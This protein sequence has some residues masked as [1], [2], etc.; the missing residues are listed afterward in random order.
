MKKIV[1]ITFLILSFS[2]VKA[3][4]LND[5]TKELK[6]TS[7]YQMY[8][9]MG[10]TK[11]TNDNN[12]IT[13]KYPSIK[14]DKVINTV[15]Y[16]L[17]N[18]TLENTFKGDI[19][20]RYDILDNNEP[21]TLEIID[22]IAKLNG[23]NNKE[24]L[25]INEDY[26]KSTNFNDDKLEVKYSDYSIVNLEGELEKDKIITSFK[27]SLDYKIREDKID[28][29]SPSIKVISI[30]K[31]KI[32]LSIS[33][34]LDNS[35]CNLY[36]AKEDNEFLYEKVGS[37]DCSKN[38]KNNKISIDVKEIN[39]YYFRAYIDNHLVSS[40]TLKVNA[41]E[42]KDKNSYLVLLIGIVFLSLIIIGRFKKVIMTYNECE[43]NDV[44]KELKRRKT[45]LKRLKLLKVVLVKEKEKKSIL[46]RDNRGYLEDKEL[47]EITKL[48]NEIKNLEFY[49]N[50]LQSKENVIS[51]IVEEEL[52]F[53][54]KR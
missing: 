38:S 25:S 32:T 30:N 29:E 1:F 27:I 43:L 2:N 3:L 15:T 23:N 54:S 37:V 44:R 53:K 41:S 28:L 45:E 9:N 51:K 35:T 50:N 31:E 46:K 20:N 4:S 11:V 49:V 19:N 42:L 16:I 26:L 8:Q 14:D 48:T 21:W 6:E 12:K 13:I 34:H 33:S 47:A 22:I 5:I 10:S 52:L 36:Y 39:D 7:T 18:N 40:A 17:K 24:I